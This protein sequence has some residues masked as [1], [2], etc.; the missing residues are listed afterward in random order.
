MNYSSLIT[1]FFPEIFRSDKVSVSLT[2]GNSHR[3]KRTDQNAGC[4]DVGQR[5]TSVL[6]SQIK[7]VPLW[8]KYPHSATWF[9]RLF[10]GQRSLTPNLDCFIK[11][12]VIHCIL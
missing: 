4:Q 3:I 11:L 6:L 7:R 8:M 2:F 12:H 1:H 5:M 10:S 9:N